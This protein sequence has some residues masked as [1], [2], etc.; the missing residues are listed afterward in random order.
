MEPGTT[1][2]ELRFSESRQRRVVAESPRQRR[3]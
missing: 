3:K 1:N 2:D